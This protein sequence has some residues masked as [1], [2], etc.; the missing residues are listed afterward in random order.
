MDVGGA[1]VTAYALRVRRSATS[2][3]GAGAFVV[4]DL[5]FTSA[6]CCGAVATGPGR[7]SGTAW[8]ATLGNLEALAS[9]DVEV[10][11]VNSVGSGT[12]AA[13]L[14]VTT[15]GVHSSEPP[16]NVRLSVATGGSITIAWDSP[17]DNGGAAIRR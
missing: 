13:P 5:Q 16:G 9:Y 15:M 12:S 14:A 3:S 7:V 2:N 1:S 8:C 4:P 10:S 11:A 6:A 17:F